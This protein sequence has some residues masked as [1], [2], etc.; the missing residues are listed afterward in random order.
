ME[1]ETR[2]RIVSNIRIGTSGW[3]YDSWLGAFYPRDIRK[4]D[5][6]HYYATQFDTTELNAP[7]Y[8]TPSLETVKAWRE[9]T[10]PGFCFAWKASRFITH[11][12]R[13]SEKSD[14]SIALLKTRLKR[15]GHKTG[16]VLFQLPPQFK[17]NRERLA[18]FLTLLPDRHR[19]TFEFRDESWYDTKIFEL[20]RENNIALCISDHA[21]APAPWE[22]TANFIYVRG[23][24][25]TGRYRGHYSDKTL[26]LW[27]RR[28]RHWHR[29]RD[30]VF[31]YFD[32]DQ[33]SAAPADAQTLRALLK[34]KTSDSR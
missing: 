14:I 12:K 15:L 19:Y 5:L 23:H 24:G 9:Q 30:D 21:D 28:I 2:A 11:W 4:K 18:A 17:A 3:H 27:A 10:P 20:L 26:Q 8:R 1:A 6:L 32:N 34:L 29:Q 16:P 25:P 22:V 7:F 13:L 31:C 33:K